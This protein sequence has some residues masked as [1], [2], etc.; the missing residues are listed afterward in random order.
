MC[1]IAAP[2]ERIDGGQAAREIAA[3]FTSM[4]RSRRRRGCFASTLAKAGTDVVTLAALMG[5]ADPSVTLRIYSHLIPG[6][7]AEA[8]KRLDGLFGDEHPNRAWP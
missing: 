2:G 8:A 7:K 3:P 4:D 1:S 5:H 6:A